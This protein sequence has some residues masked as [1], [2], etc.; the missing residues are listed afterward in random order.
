M[1]YVQCAVYAAYDALFQPTNKMILKSKCKQPNHLY[2]ELVIFSAL[3][4][5]LTS[6]F[7][8]LDNID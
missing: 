1:Q 6:N 7:K 2:I 4:I 5:S 8:A 3:S